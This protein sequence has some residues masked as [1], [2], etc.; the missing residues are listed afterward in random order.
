MLLGQTSGRLNSGSVSQDGKSGPWSRRKPR[1][2]RDRVSRE[3]GADL[4]PGHLP[5][6][7]L[8]C[9]LDH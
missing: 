9:A 6:D 4:V 8:G 7:M 5:S 3:L 1:G 2:W